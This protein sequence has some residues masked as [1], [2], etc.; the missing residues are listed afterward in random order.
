MSGC[1]RSASAWV[2]AGTPAVKNDGRVLVIRQNI[3]QPVELVWRQIDRPG[4]TP[5]PVLIRTTQVNDE[6]RCAFIDLLL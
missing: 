4:D 2:S 1:D 6:Q 3:L 5:H